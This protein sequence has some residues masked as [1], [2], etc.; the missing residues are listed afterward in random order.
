MFSLLT[1]FLHVRQNVGALYRQNS[2]LNWATARIYSSWA[3]RRTTQYSKCFISPNPEQTLEMSSGEEG[4]FCVFFQQLVLDVKRLW[5]SN[6]SVL[7]HMDAFPL[8]NLVQ[9][10][11]VR[12][13]VYGVTIMS[14]RHAMILSKVQFLPDLRAAA[15][16][17][18]TPIWTQEGF[19]LSVLESDE[20]GSARLSVFCENNDLCV[21]C[22]TVRM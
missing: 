9:Q 2:Q 14:F 10:L 12:P 4:L 21:S 19:L 13:S 22:G 15:C 16:V 7:Y 20:C 17:F 3:W 1:Q 6:S 8:C 18:C 11:V 5:R